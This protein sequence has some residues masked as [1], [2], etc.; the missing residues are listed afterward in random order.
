VGCTP[1]DLPLQLDSRLLALG[2]VADDAGDQQAALS[3][4]RTQ[5]NLDW[6]DATI[7][8]FGHQIEAHAHGPGM[9][10]SHIS[11]AVARMKRAESFRQQD[12]HR[13]TDQLTAR[14]AKHPLGLTIH[15]LPAVVDNHDRVG[16]GRQERLEQALGRSKLV[17]HG[18]ATHQPLVYGCL[19]CLITP[20][21]RII[22]HSI[23]LGI[24]GI[25]Q[26]CRYDTRF[27]CRQQLRRSRSEPGAQGLADYWSTLTGS[28]DM[29]S[30]S[31]RAGG[32]PSNS[33]TVAANWASSTG[34]AM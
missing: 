15:D 34:L 6:E 2:D 21:L 27:A 20:N 24:T 14:V 17:W 29:Y 3:V 7:L 32:R 26:S 28:D 9:R 25:R 4:E 22:S 1:L 11:S 10:F 19:R 12:I 8:A 13:L 33:P 23:P 18:L 16:R 5:A 31:L 30:R